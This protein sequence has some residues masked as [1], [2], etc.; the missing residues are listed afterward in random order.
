MSPGERALVHGVRLSRG[1]QD[2]ELAGSGVSE[3]WLGGP[4]PVSL[5]RDF[6]GAVG[7]LG[8]RP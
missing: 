1:A 4:G 7:P 3:A 5:A 8:V 2:S 6:T